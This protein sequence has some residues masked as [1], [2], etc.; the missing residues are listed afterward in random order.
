MFTART[1]ELQDTVTY[2]QAVSDPVKGYVNIKVAY[3]TA[4]IVKTCEDGMVDGNHLSALQ[5]NGV[6]ETVQTGKN[7]GQIQVDNLTPGE[8]IPSPSRADDKYEPQ[9]SP[10]CYR[11]E[12]ARRRRSHSTMC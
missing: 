8:F 2:A 9:E 6:D 10:P 1:A 12:P 11:C 4:K 5:G 3:G 7:G